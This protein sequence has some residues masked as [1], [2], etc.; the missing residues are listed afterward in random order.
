MLALVCGETIG[1]LV[2]ALLTLD[3]TTTVVDLDA[4]YGGSYGYNSLLTAG[5]IMFFFRP[6]VVSCALAVFG[7]L[8][9]KRVY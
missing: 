7:G 3:H 1:T 2:V 8:V 6:T 4:L 9:C 5:A